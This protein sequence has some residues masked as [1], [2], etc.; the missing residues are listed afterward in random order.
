ML[1]FLT[2]FRYI[3]IFACINIAPIFVAELVLQH[4]DIPH[5]FILS[6]VDGDLGC[7]QLL[8]VMNKAAINL[9]VQVFMWTFVFI[10]LE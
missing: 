1:S 6:P 8:A 7:F 9:S 5:L 10:S 4:M 2:Y 3:H